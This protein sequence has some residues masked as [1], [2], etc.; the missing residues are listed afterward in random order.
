MTETRYQSNDSGNHTTAVMY[1]IPNI[2]TLICGSLSA[3]YGAFSGC[4]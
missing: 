4:G 1:T 3:R 2:Q